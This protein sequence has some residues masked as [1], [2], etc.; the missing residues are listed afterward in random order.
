MMTVDE[1]QS[2]LEELEQLRIALLRR[3]MVYQ[4][5]L[6]EE[7]ARFNGVSEDTYYYLRYD[8]WDAIRTAYLKRRNDNG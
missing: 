4:V 8:K 1:I 2:E 5:D 7:V 6:K 3:S